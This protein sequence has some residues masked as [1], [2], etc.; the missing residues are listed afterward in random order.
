MLLLRTV[1][2]VGRA[3]SLCL[4]FPSAAL[5]LTGICPDGSVFIV[6]HE[7]QVPCKAAKEVEPGEVPP[8]RPQYLPNPY[9]W[10]VY[11][12]VQDPNNPYNLIDSV[13]DIRAL[14]GPGAAPGSATPEES[15]PGAGGAWD[16]GASSGAPAVSA[17][18]P[19]LAA[20]HAPVGPLDLGLADQELR[21]LYQIVELSQEQT[22]AAFE[23]KTAD[24]RGVMR[25]ALAHSLAFEQRLQQAWQ[26]RGGLGTSSVVLFSA[27][28]KQADAFHPNL[29]FV[30]A[31]LTFQPDPAN[32]RQLGVLQGRLGELEAGEIVLGYVILPEGIRADAPLDVYWDDRRLAV[33]FPN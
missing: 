20:R 23:R 33:Q 8:L 1:W 14:H 11:N 25:L 5:A 26:S 22:P 15:L 29:T 31:H 21:D 17:P 10:H 16:E 24:G 19:Q 9:T 30:Q 13:R 3:T 28:S 2:G 27:G 12:E 18:P 4:V 7:S 32:P 6:Q